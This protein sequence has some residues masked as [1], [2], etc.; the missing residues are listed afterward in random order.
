ML[1]CKNE[2]NTFPEVWSHSNYYDSYEEWKW[3]RKKNI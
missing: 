3:E 2:P 1:V